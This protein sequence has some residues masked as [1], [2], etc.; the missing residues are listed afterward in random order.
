MLLFQVGLKLQEEV[1]HFWKLMMVLVLKG[2]RLLLTSQ[3]L[4][5]KRL[6]N[7]LKILV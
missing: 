5:W 3:Y 7:V 1:Q 4:I 2:C 6:N